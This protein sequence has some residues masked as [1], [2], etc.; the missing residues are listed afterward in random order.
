MQELELDSI[1]VCFVVLLATNVLASVVSSARAQSQ[2]QL[3]TKQVHDWPKV[4]KHV[5]VLIRPVRF[6]V[7]L[8]TSSQE[9]DHASALH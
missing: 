7:A 5:L 9:Q 6:D 3:K 8:G 1:H 2:K 4:A